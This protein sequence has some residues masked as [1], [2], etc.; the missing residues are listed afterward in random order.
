MGTNAICLMSLQ[1]KGNPGIERNMQTGK[2][3]CE[4]EGRD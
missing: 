1:K 4:G 3:P 2:I